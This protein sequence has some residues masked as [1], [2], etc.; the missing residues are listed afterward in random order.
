MKIMPW[1]FFK[2]HRFLGC[3]HV[4]SYAFMESSLGISAWVQIVLK[5]EAFILG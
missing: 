5:V 4:L 3:R 1:G 2:V